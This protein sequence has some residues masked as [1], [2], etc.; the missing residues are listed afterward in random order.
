MASG[1]QQLGFAI[2]A[3]NEASKVLKDVQKDLDGVDKHSSSAD[4]ALGGVGKALG[5]LGSPAKA[6]AGALGDVVKIAGG[7]VLGQGILQAPGFFMDAAKAAAEDEAATARLANTFQNYANMAGAAPDTFQRLNDLLNDRITIGQDLA[8][9]DDAVRDSFSTLLAATDDSTEA[10]RRQQAAFD[11]SRG[12]GISL[13][14][15]TRML[16]KVNDENVDSFKRLGIE[17]PKTATEADALAAVQARFGGAADAYAQSTAGQFEQTKIRMGELKEQIGTA[18][19]PVMTQIGEVLVT[20][21]VPKLEQFAGFWATSVQPKVE[22]FIAWLGPQLTRAGQYFDTEI[23]P[24]IESFV[25]ATIPLLQRLGQMVQEQFGKF[26]QYYQSDV[27]PA[28]DNITRAVEEVVTWVRQH[29]GQIEGIVRPIFE[30]VQNVVETAMGVIRETLQIIVD[31]LGG[32]FSGAWNNT[33]E[34]VSIVIQYW[35]D[36]VS[37]GLEFIRGMGSTMLDIGNWLFDQLQAGASEA[38]SRIWSWLLGLPGE[39]RKTFTDIDWL[40]IGKDILRGIG[41]GI[42]AMRGWII[43]KVTGIAGEIAGKLNPKNWIGSPKGIQNWYPYYLE[44]GL[45]NMADVALKSPYPGIAAAAVAA[46]L[47]ASLSVVGSGGAVKTAGDYTTTMGVA[48]GYTG[49]AEVITDIVSLIKDVARGKVTAAGLSPDLLAIVE[50]QYRATG[51]PPA[52]FYA[53][54]LG[55]AMMPATPAE[56]LT[57][58]GYTG[59]S[60]TTYVVGPGGATVRADALPGVTVV[61]EGSVYGVDDLVYTMDRALKRAGEAGL[62]A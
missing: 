17:L 46:P 19:L 49:P 53:S 23:R 33:K 40:E 52:G 62:V 45:Q 42:E 34:L 59:A 22:A 60:G 56:P 41:D 43:D 35:K 26:Q 15:A 58:P 54:G 18:L 11:L 24:K 44:Q 1:N 36:T 8:F 3:I 6:A 39:I 51:G 55:G 38:W 37:N 2:R 27:K 20:E 5:A 61:V 25:N 16:S 14:A 9:S 10:V 4:R 12:A 47:A 31:L 7:F 28:I 57:V 50:D 21:V 13:E 32:D 48:P 29:W 30:Q